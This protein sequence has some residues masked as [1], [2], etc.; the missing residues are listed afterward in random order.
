[1]Q[2]IRIVLALAIL[3]TS[4]TPAAAMALHQVPVSPEEVVRGDPS[5]PWIS[6][7]FNAGAGYTP[8]EGILDVLREREVRTT[9]F[10]MGWWA[11]RQPDLVRRIA[12][13]GHEVG[14]HGQEV[15]D[16]TS[17]SDTAVVADLERADAVLSPLTG[18]TTRPLWSPSAG[19]RDARVR[20]LAASLGYRPI[21]WTLDSGDW[22]FEATA[23]GVRRRV[24]NGAVNGAIIVMHFDSPRSADTMAA[25]LPAVIDGLRAQGYRLVTITELVTGKLDG[26]E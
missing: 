25:E 8:A 23:D 11:E 7:V 10:L 12:A 22:T 2:L 13:E 14:S 20:G 5:R 15:F 9:F 17:V 21:Y 18:R 24:L 4:L 26:D 19:Y 1:M 6:L 16:L 3:A